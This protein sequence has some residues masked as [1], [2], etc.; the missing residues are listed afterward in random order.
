MLLSAFAVDN[1]TGGKFPSL[2]WYVIRQFLM[3]LVRYGQSLA[4][5]AMLVV[6]GAEMSD[7]SEIPLGL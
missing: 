5:K 7:L 2:S 3:L 4:L 1:F 6:I